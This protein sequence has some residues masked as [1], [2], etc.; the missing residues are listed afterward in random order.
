[1]AGN[2]SAG[3]F[4]V[5]FRAAATHFNDGAGWSKSRRLR[6]GTDVTGYGIIVDVSRLTATVADKENTVMQA[7]GVTVGDECVAAFH[8]AHKVIGNEQVKDPI[9]AVRRDPPSPT[10]G[11]H[12]CDVV[13]GCRSVE[14]C[15]RVKNR[16][17]HVSP[18]LTCCFQRRLGRPGQG[19][20]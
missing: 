6:C 3:I 18:L 1:M 20:T 4:S 10:I 15:Y 7:A 2:K 12:V 11:N 13:R 19:G 17:T 8:P 5:A 16:G 9:H 14:S